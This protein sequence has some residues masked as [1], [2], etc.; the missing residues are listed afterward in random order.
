MLVLTRKTGQKLIINDN[1]EVVILETKGES[2][3]IGIKA[4][5]EVTIFREEIYEEIKKAN[6]QAGANALIADIDGALNLFDKKKKSVDDYLSKFNAVISIQ[7]Q[8]KK[9]DK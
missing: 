9:P 1:I 4:P 6:E 5:R 7:K 2:V 8:D 3:K